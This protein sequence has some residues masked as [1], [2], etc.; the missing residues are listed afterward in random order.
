LGC[1]ARP[2][3]VRSEATSLDVTLREVACANRHEVSCE[4]TPSLPFDKGRRALRFPRQLRLSKLRSIAFSVV[5]S[6][7][8]TR[9]FVKD[10]SV[11]NYNEIVMFYID[12][13]AEPLYESSNFVS[14]IRNLYFY[15]ISATIDNVNGFIS[16]III[17]IGFALL[18]YLFR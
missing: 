3:G 18:C 14:R 5:T 17:I 10:E 15:D 12:N 2:Y 4:A 16:Y 8:A 6:M 7:R 13:I 1:G 9:K 11:S